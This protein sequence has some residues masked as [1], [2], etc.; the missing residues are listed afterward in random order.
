[1]NSYILALR[2]SGTDINFIVYDFI[3]FV[4][5]LKYFKKEDC[6]PVLVVTLPYRY[7]LTSVLL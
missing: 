7:C 4:Y 2:C 6:L 3:V 5:S 1:M